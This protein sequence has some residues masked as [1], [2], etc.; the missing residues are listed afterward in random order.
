MYTTVNLGR[1]DPDSIPE[2]GKL[3]GEFDESDI[4]RL[5]GV[6][7]RNLFRLADL[8]IHVREVEDGFDGSA[9]SDHR[10]RRFARRAADTVA[11]LDPAESYSPFDAH[12]ARFYAWRGAPAPRGTALFSTV[13]AGRMNKARTAEVRRIFTE[14]DGTD[15]PEKMGTRWR[16]LYLYRDV[17]L[18]LQHF[19][20]PDGGELIDQAWREADPRFIKACEELMAIIPPYDPVT[21]TVPAD[22]VA[23]CFYEWEEKP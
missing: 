20:R 21:W 5:S 11:A 18:H 8:L 17:Y 1:M 10:S 2:V 14:L 7:R 3:F 22:S 15:I 9:L 23:T 19:T 12:A 13:I 16:Q 6:R 4:N